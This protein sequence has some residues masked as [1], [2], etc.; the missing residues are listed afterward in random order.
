MEKFKKIVIGIAVLETIAYIILIVGSGMYGE[1]YNLVYNIFSLILC[2]FVLGMIYD[3]LDTIDDIV[4]R[5]VTTS[6]KRISELSDLIRR[7]SFRIAELEERLP[8][9]SESNDK[10]EVVLQEKEIQE[11][12]TPVTDEE[13][14][15]A[16]KQF[17]EYYRNGFIKV[18]HHTTPDAKKRFICPFCNT[19]Q[20]LIWEDCISC[21]RK[22]VYLQNSSRETNK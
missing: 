5:S 7:L 11:D 18:N 14:V 10:N 6:G 3:F 21:K 17:N 15:F 8:K 9:A 16:K 13:I 1:T 19:N 2:W 20:A 22:I 12:D 4:L